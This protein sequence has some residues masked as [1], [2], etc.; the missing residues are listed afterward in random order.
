ME[1]PFEIL[2]QRLD[3]I[4]RLLYEII[5]QKLAAN[6]VAKEVMNVEEVAQYLDVAKSTIYK[7]TST[8]EIPH[9]KKGKRIY[10]RTNEINEWMAKGKRKTNDEIKEEVDLYLIN[11][12]VRK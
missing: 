6:G 5:Q 1:N 9:F 2:M 3:N 7:L 11:R 12:K 10:F 4:E 8:R